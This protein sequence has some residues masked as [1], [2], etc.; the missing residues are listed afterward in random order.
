MKVGA[1][2]NRVKIW[3][4]IFLVVHVGYAVYYEFTD[5]TFSFY[6]MWMALLCILLLIWQQLI[7]VNRYLYYL[8]QVVEKVNKN[9][10][11][12]SGG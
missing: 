1:L 3:L 4:L 6:S 2:Q 7:T 9:P 12:P 10:Y 8:W 5:T 11:D